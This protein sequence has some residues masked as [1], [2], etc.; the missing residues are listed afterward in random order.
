MLEHLLFKG[1]AK[2]KSNPE[3]VRPPARAGEDAREPMDMS[4]VLTHGSS[5]LVTHRPKFL[6]NSSGQVQRDHWVMEPS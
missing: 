4:G 3:H 6:R 1:L 2:G 5:P